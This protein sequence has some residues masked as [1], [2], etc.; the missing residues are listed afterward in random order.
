MDVAGRNVEV[1][2]AGYA[3]F[4]RADIETLT[5]VFAEDASWHTPGKSS[6]AGDAIGREQVFAQFGRYGG[7][8]A[9]TF[10]AGLIE[11]FASPDGRVVGLHHNR[12]ERDGKQLEGGPGLVVRGLRASSGNR[13]VSA[14]A[15]LR[16]HHEGEK[17]RARLRPRAPRGAR[18]DP[19]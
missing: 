4:N 11:V 5:E 7:E 1:V 12:G 17:V 16:V 6:M 14:I 3:A 9:G 18:P 2:R 13:S 15:T 10:K 19:C 8:T